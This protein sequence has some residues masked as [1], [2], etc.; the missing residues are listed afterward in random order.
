MKR[1]T[2]VVFGCL[3]VVADCLVAAPVEENATEKP[4]NVDVYTSGEAGYHTFRI[5]ALLTSPKGTLLAFC[6]GRKTGRGDHG[7]L[8][9]VLKRSSDG[10]NTWGKLQLVYEEGGNEKIT[11]GNPCPVVDQ[12]NG[13]IWLPFTRNNDDVLVT[14][15]DD[16]GQTWAEPKRI[17]KSVKD[18]AWTWYATGP[19]VGIQLTRGEHKGRLVIPCDHRLRAADGGWRGAGHSHVI[20]SDD[21]GQTWQ[22]G[23]PTE[24]SMNECQVVELSDGRLMLNMRS[25]RGHGCRAVAISKDG[26]VTWGECRDDES[27]IEPVCQASFV[28]YS[29][30]QEGKSRLLFSNPAST[31]ARDHMTIRLSTDEGK[32]WPIDRLLYAGS[33]AYSS[34]ARLPDDEIGILYERDAYKTIAFTRFSLDWLT[35]QADADPQE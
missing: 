19:G 28:R 1:T 30:P 20:Y 21:H 7:D 34:L 33:A 9:M 15:S 27:L 14:Y 13:R 10:G 11:I 5:P 35:T 23:E 31:K 25:Y 24:K 3:L 6:E 16:E 12:S 29:W 18:E 17:T 8:D 22:K 26:G 2:A 32:T 4:A